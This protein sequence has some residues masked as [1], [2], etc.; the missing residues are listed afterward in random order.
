MLK[1]G[2]EQIRDADRRRLVT[3][4]LG[5][6]KKLLADNL[7][8]VVVFGSVARGQSDPS[9]DTDIILVGSDMPRSL[10]ERMDL[11]AKLLVEFSKSEI[12]QELNQ[13]GLNTWVQFHPLRMEE[14]KLHRP[15]YL[16]VVEDGIIIY[17]KGDFIKRV[18][19]G[20]RSKLEALGAR[21][22]FLEDGSW[23][24]DLKPGMKRGEVIEV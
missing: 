20:F 6:L 1:I 14:A 4:L 12:C 10:S 13:K 5:L 23:Y 21:R 11:L 15:I 22:V 17:D 2:L 18:M 7:I 24:W 3:C 8:S 16:D 19:E 9:S